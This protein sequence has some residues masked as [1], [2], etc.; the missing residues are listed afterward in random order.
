M[1]SSCGDGCSLG[2]PWARAQGPIRSGAL[3]SYEDEEPMLADKTCVPCR[4]GVPPLKGDKL[5]EIQRQLADP[6][7]WNIVNEHLLVRTFKFPDFRAAL[8]FVN[9]VR[10]LAEDQGHHPDSL[11]GWGKGE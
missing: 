5:T 7:Q 3:P 10:Q 8:A 11:L 4:G 2:L 9:R 1:P 6:A